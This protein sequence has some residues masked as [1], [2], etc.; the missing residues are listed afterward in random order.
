MTSEFKKGENYNVILAEDNVD[1]QRLIKELLRKSNINLDIVYNGQELLAKLKQGWKYDLILMDI[2]MPVMDG[3]A[4][5][6]AIRK[7][8]RY[9]DLLIIGLTAFAM[10]GDEHIAMMKGMNDYITKPINKDDLFTTIGR[11]LKLKK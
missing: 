2:Q 3:Y 8:P 4:A 11:Y 6:E 10:G 1:H 9:K 7:D 5:T